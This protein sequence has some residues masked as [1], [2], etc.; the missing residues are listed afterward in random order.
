MNEI[1]KIL[2][3]RFSSFGDIV[4]TFPLINLLKKKFPDSQI[5]FLVKEQYVSLVEINDKIDS[6]IT[7]PEDT[8]LSTLRNELK[9]TDYDIVLDLQNN[10]K[11]RIVTSGM[12]NLS[13]FKKHNFEKFM[14]VRFKINLLKDVPPVYQRYI[15]T[16]V[17]YIELSEDDKVFSGSEIKHSQTQKP[18]DNYYVIAPSS[19]HFTK[20]YPKEK[21]V[22]FINSNKNENYVLVG[23]NSEIDLEI[24][25]FI[26]SK[27]D[28]V[29]ELC[30][31]LS[32]SELAFII[33]ESDG[34]ITND[35]G[36][37]HF[38]ESLGKPV[39][40]I[41]GSTVKEFGFFP[42]L[43]DSKV[44]ENLELRC[45]PCSHIGLLKCPKGHFKCM[46]ELSIKGV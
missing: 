6:I 22:E 28:N 4:L 21:F 12:N 19:R 1:K 39:T 15:D 10:P 36:V 32:Y 18:F 11:S 5:T 29:S 41:F 8:P 33:N 43:A 40:A 9:K 25:N 16:V 42:Q 35:S 44:I 20:T 26:E 7:L 23:D 3:V 45:R 17:K 38:A 27:C 31:K 37:L 46:M 34:V 13:R 24:C 14:L 2:V 30:G